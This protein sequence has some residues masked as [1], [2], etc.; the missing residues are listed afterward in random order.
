MNTCKKV[1]EGPYRACWRNRPSDYD[2]RPERSPTNKSEV[3]EARSLRPGGGC[4]AR[5]VRFG[6]VFAGTLFR[7]NTCKK[8]GWGTLPF[9]RDHCAARLARASTQFRGTR[10]LLLARSPPGS[11]LLSSR[12]P[13]VLACAAT[14][15][16][17]CR[18]SVL[19]RTEPSGGDR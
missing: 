8:W 14:V 2:R 11:I 16:A 18:F 3:S 10:G 15:A 7:M 4:G 9:F 13:D 6:C 17:L 5:C 12:I 1:R 19:P